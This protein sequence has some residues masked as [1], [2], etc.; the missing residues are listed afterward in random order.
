MFIG[1]LFGGPPPGPPS[2]GLFGGPPPGPPS[3]GLFG[4]SSSSSGLFGGPPPGPPSGGLFGGPPPGPPSGGL[5]GASS[6]SSG[7]FGGPPP[8]PPSGGLFGQPQSTSSGLFG[9]PPSSSGAPLC[10]RSF[11]GSPFSSGESSG[12]PPPPSVGSLG[13]PLS[14]KLAAPL[15]PTVAHLSNCS[16]FNYSLGRSTTSIGG[17]HELLTKIISLQKAEGFWLL[18]E[19]ATQIIHKNLADLIDLCPVECDKRA[20]ATAL[21][22][23]CLEKKFVAQKDEWELVATKAELWLE[24]IPEKSTINKLTESAKNI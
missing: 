18:D 11:G 6:S 24:Q 22:L 12:G 2:G 5:F 4:A 7:L 21:V 10:G 16:A 1:R 9:G 14:S 13:G 8:G 19:V 17:D 3:G 15:V 23:A 20:W